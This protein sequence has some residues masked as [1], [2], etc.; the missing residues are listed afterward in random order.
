VTVALAT[1][2]KSPNDAATPPAASG[3]Y[4]ERN[5]EMAKKQYIAKTHIT[6]NNE[7][8]EAGD[9]IELDDKTEAP[10]LLKVKAIEPA[11]AKKAETK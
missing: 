10:E 7:P 9:P 2:S 5:P 6:H 3:G 8:F 11:P 1:I 4:M